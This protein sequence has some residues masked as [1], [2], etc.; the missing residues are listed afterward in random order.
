MTAP[1]TPARGEE[2]FREIDQSRLNG[3]AITLSAMAEAVKETSVL[4]IRCK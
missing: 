4:R 2:D 1:T 3:R